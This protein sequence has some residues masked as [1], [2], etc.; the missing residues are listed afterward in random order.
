MNNGLIRFNGSKFWYKN[1]LL[2]KE[3]GPAI[4]YVN[5]NK[6][7]YLHGELHRADGPAIEYSNGKNS[8][9]LNDKPI[10]CLTQEAFERLLKLKAFW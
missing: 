3:D 9:Y 8:W 10:N 6:Y 2:H 4:E 1:D 7:W 5:G